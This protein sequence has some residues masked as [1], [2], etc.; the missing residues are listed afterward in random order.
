MACVICGYSVSNC[1]RHVTYASVYRYE[2]MLQCWQKR[3]P[4]RPTFISILDELAPEMSDRF[5][6]VSFYF[7]SMELRSEQQSAHSSVHNLESIDELSPP[8]D[9]FPAADPV[10]STDQ[11]RGTDNEI[12]TFRKTWLRNFLPKLTFL[13]RRR[14]ASAL[15]PMLSALT[16]NSSNIQSSGTSGD[17]RRTNMANGC[18]DPQLSVHR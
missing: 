15:R 7:S 17:Y 12:P 3:A 2:M 18:A 1:A 6:R 11:S 10:S 8:N 13:R 14:D 16:S 5:H 9:R 4:D